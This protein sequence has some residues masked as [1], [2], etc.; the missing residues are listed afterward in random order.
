MLLPDLEWQANFLKCQLAVQFTT[1]ND[2]V[3][4]MYMHIYTYAFTPAYEYT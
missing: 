4:H 1:E 2:C 3:I